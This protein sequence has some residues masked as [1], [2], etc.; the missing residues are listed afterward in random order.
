MD[1]RD[2]PVERP[3]SLDEKGWHVK[4][5]P[6]DVSGFWRVWRDVFYLVLI[7]IFLIIPWTKVN[8][9]Q[10]ILL[11][12]AHRRFSLFG[13]TFWAHDVPLVFFLLA[14][15]TIGIM[16]VTSIFGRV[17]CGWACPQTVFIDRI[18]RK[19]ERWIEGS[20]LQREKLD[21]GPWTGEKISKKT[22]KWI[23]F[24]LISSTIA[25]SFAAYFLGAEQLVNMSLTSPGENW[26]AFLTVTFITAVLL[27]DFGWFREQFC[28]IMCPYGRFQSVLMDQ[29]SLAVVYDE[30]RGEPRRGTDPNKQGDCV[31]C[32]RCVAVCPTGI[33]IRRGL[34]MECIACT[35]CIDA[36]DEVM[37][38][39]NKPKG[40]I[41]YASLNS[42]AGEPFRLLKPRSIIY[43]L[44]LL[45]IAGGFV[46][47]VSQRSPL[48]VQFIRA[49][50]SP[51]TVQTMD[52]GS[53]VVTNHFVLRLKNHQFEGQT[54][55]ISVPREGIRVIAP[56][57]PLTLEAG[58]AGSAH[59][60]FN[61]GGLSPSEKGRRPVTIEVTAE[62][63]KGTT[64]YTTEVPLVGPMD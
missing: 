3:S 29:D 23:F 30:K 55:S 42:L 18:Y 64:T 25:H 43:C 46:Y 36:C 58:K 7:A 52:D 31:A 1:I 35:A 19:V 57:L 53:K 54:V 28:I 50:D 62:T 11:D 49:V 47:A 60:F 37:V 48:D 24:F 41:R 40:L 22:L 45:V 38:K 44:I 20:H 59:V 15:A 17:W 13:V 6:A 4:I 14:L 8:G 21:K 27:F 10:T 26:V 9:T 16:V 2:V 63:S 12:I 32:Y 34:Q 33:D 5:H 61:F 51:Y 39:V 56:T